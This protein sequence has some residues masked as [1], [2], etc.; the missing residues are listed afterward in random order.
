[1]SCFFKDLI[2][3][4][5]IIRTFVVCSCSCVKFSESANPMDRESSICVSSSLAEPVAMYR[6]WINS[7]TPFRL[8]LAPSAILL[9]IETAQR[10]IWEVIP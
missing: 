1:M 9:G 3:P 4:R 5:S 10:R 6:N 8:R 7:L 2:R